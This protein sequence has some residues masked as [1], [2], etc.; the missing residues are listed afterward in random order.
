MADWDI[1]AD[2]VG[3]AQRLMVAILIIITTFDEPTFGEHMYPCIPHCGCA[4]HHKTLIIDCTNS[5]QRHLPSEVP[6]APQYKLL[7]RNNSIEALEMRDYL[8]RVY[9]L[10]VSFNN[11]S[12][13]SSEAFT[14]L[15]HHVKVLQLH[16]NHI[17]HLPELF[18]GSNFQQ[19]ESL[20][21]HGNW[22]VCNCRAKSLKHW[23]L[24]S[25]KVSKPERILCNDRLFFKRHL[26]EIA[27]NQFPCDITEFFRN[28]GNPVVFLLTFIFAII[29]MW[30]SL[31]I[32]Y[33][34]CKTSSEIKLLRGEKW[35]ALRNT[36]V[37]ESNDHWRSFSSDQETV[38]ADDK[39]ID[40]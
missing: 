2:L 29:F 15:Q 1:Y 30:V 33:K 23:V 37:W 40:S 3:K 24:N 19:L 10:D 26:L 8:P 16:N 27:D 34:F 20:T 17:S 39:P 7:L 22:L 4:K 14:T 9:H 31:C 28:F 18:R 38:L 11:I 5:K 6:L 35:T 25:T 36:N 13:I 12:R 21:L 32:L